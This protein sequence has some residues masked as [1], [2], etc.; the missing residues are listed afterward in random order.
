M[1]QFILMLKVKIMKTTFY[2]LLSLKTAKG[3]ESFGKF[4][5]GEDEAVARQTFSLLK[6]TADVGESDVLLLELME[7]RQGLPFNLN[8]LG[9]TLSELGENCKMI[10]MET[11]KATN[12]KEF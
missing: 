4:F 7:T 9:C 10:A 11:F 3:H 8:V 12:L 5:L 1:I 6:G 2:L